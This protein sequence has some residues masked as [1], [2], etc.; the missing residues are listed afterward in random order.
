MSVARHLVQIHPRLVIAFAL[1]MVV[2]FLCPGAAMVTRLLVAWNAGVW[3]YLLLMWLKMMRARAADIKRLA[4]IEDESAQLV[5]VTVCVAAVASLAAIILELAGAAH[6]DQSQRF[7]R[8]AFTGGTVLGSWFLIGTIF[9]I[10]YARLFYNN[11]DDDHTADGGLP[12]RFADGEQNPDYWDFLYFSFTISV[13]VQ[14]SD[15]SVATRALRK[16]VLAHSIIGFLFN[17]AILGLSINI[18]AGLAA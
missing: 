4:E 13:A 5:L 14:T 18:A 1:G 11:E 3:S 9:T 7:L 10:H 8:Y 2:Y 6:L 15:V 12:L 17:A 16:T